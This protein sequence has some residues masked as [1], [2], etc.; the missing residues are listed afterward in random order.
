MTLLLILSHI[1]FFC[2]LFYYQKKDQ[3]YI[4]YTTVLTLMFI[5]SLLITIFIPKIFNEEYKGIL[6]VLI[7]SNWVFGSV[8]IYITSQLTLAFD[9]IS[10]LSRH[11]AIKELED[12]NKNQSS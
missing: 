10:K 7:F 11:I 12:R 3:N 5:V 6:L 4:G 8:I 1:C 2:I 9:K